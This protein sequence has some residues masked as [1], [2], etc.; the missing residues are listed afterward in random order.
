[1]KDINNCTKQ[2]HTGC[3]HPISFVGSSG[4]NK[5]INKDK[6]ATGMSDFNL[7]KYDKTQEGS[8]TQP[9]IFTRKEDKGEICGVIVSSR[10]PGIKDGHACFNKKPCP[11]HTA[12][13]RNPEQVEWDRQLV[14]IC[15]IW[16]HPDYRTSAYVELKSF[17]RNLLSTREE[18]IKEK[19][20]GII[21]KYWPEVRDEGA[22]VE[23]LSPEIPVSLIYIYKEIRDL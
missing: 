20:L 2:N 11:I 23:E 22:H 13:S 7:D 4:Y 16:M 9:W 21:T 18:K 8:S 3:S 15:E 19:A 12:P 1:M 14:G 17:I 5:D 6:G 10:T